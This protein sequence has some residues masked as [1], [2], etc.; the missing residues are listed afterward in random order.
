LNSETSENFQKKKKRK[1]KQYTAKDIF[2][3]SFSEEVSR[4]FSFGFLGLYRVQRIHLRL[5]P[6]FFFFLAEGILGSIKE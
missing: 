6:V 2:F 1:E 4:L 3:T 5:Y